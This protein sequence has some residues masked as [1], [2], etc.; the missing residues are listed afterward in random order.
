MNINSAPIS[1]DDFQATIISL[2]EKDYSDYGTSIYD[3]DE[4]DERE[5]TVYMI[6]NDESYPKVEGSTFNVYYKYNYLKDKTEL[7]R[8]VK[9]GPDEILPA[10][11][12]REIPW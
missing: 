8:K 9:K 3:W 11:S 7:N 1:W 2:L 5:R 10:T 12:W 4:D 6:Q